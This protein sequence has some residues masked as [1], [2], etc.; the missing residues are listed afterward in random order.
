LR[1]AQTVV[2]LAQANYA[3]QVRGRAQAENALVLLVGQPSPADLPPPIRLGA[4]AILADIPEGLP[5]DLLTRRPDILQAEAI[6]RSEN[7]NIGAARA[8]FFPTIS[9]TGNLGTASAS[10]SGLF[11]GGSTFWSLMP[12]LS[13]PIFNGGALKAS[14]DVAKIQKD[15]GIAQYEKAIQTAFREVSDGLAARGTYDDQ[16]AATERYTKGLRGSFEFAA[17]RRF[18]QSPLTWECLSFE[19]NEALDRDAYI[20]EEFGTEGPKALRWFP[21]AEGEK[22][23]IGRTT[24]YSLGW[25]VGASI[26]VKLARPDKLCINL[27]GDAAIGFTGMDFETA[28]RER[29]PILSVLLNNFSMAIELKV[30]KTATDKYRST[31]ISGDYAAF[32]RALGGW[33]ER[34]TEP[35]EIV[36][37][38]KRAVE[39]TREGTPALLEFITEKAVDF[40]IF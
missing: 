6:L 12:A 30:M 21:F 13:V 27:W 17:K 16:V 24:G 26:G 9:L 11:G 40:S 8:A 28:V 4:Q 31:D 36:P 1:Q 35:G 32:A 19:I 20:V 29:I 10:L 23:K 15:I 25:G 7:A 18:D 37:A 2:E 22:T 5:S 39:R 38:V 3:A 34:V 33:G 14:L